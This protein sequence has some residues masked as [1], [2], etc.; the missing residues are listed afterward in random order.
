MRQLEDL[1]GRRFGKLVVLYRTNEQDKG[2]HYIWYCKCDCGKNT[3]ATSINLKS[4]NTKS[5]G[6]THSI[7]NNS[8]ITQHIGYS[9]TRI[10]RIWRDIKYRT[11]HN[12]EWVNHNYSEK[13]IKMC[14]EWE[15][16]SLAFYEWAIKAGYSDGLSIDRIDNNGDYTPENCRWVDQKTQ[17]RNKSTNRLITYNGETRPFC[18]WAEV[19]G[20][21]YATLYRRIFRLGWDIERAFTTQVKG[22]F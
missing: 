12:C 7:C 19:L 16:N 15:S 1:S 21:N 6:C 17:C 22:S 5:C 2:R 4:G 13:G 18:E 14:A 20:I 10:Y 11:T 9:K 3:R 8:G